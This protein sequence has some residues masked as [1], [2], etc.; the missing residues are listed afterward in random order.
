MNQIPNRNTVVNTDSL[1]IETN[2]VIVVDKNF[3]IHVV[4]KVRNLKIPKVFVYNA[5]FG[6]NNQK[7]YTNKEAITADFKCHSTVPNNSV[8]KDNTLIKYTDS[9]HATIIQGSRDSCKILINSKNI[10][11]VNKVM[12][13]NKTTV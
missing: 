12:D 13:N 3:K 11:L 1:V 5:Q 4:R 10:S 2:K 7:V 8:V 9:D 6:T